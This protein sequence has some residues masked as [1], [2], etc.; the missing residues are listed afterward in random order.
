MPSFPRRVWQIED[1]TG[2]ANA[3]SF[4]T[5]IDARTIAANYG[6]SLAV[7]DTE[8]E[9]Q[10]RQGYV[11]LL[12]LESSLQGVRTYGTQT[13]IYPR[14][15]VYSNCTAVAGDEIPQ[16]VIMAQINYADA[17]NS[18]VCTNSV[19]DGQDLS[20]FN[21]QGVY[22]ETYQDGSSKNLNAQIQGVYNSLYP[23]TKAGYAASP[24]GSGGG[25]T[26]DEYGQGWY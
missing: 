12:S 7:D 17:I 22:S 3:D 16:S 4:V 8:A 14:T 21:V 11:G 23:L 5:L 2:V 9:V 18:G 6:L 26:R 25:L 24:C 20:G 15:G 1:G 13:G 19:D 10:L